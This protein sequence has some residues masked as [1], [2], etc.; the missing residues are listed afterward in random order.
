[1]SFVAI[2]GLALGLG[3]TI[4][5]AKSGSEGKKA[6]EREAELQR[7]AGEAR[8]AAAELEA[9][10]LE[11]QAGQ[12]VA[13]AQRDMFDV[14]RATRLAESRALALSAAS[15]GGASSPTVINIIANIAKEGSYNAARA[16]Y[17]GEEQARL[18]KIHAIEKR[19]LGEFDLTAGNLAGLAAEGRGKAAVT[20]SY[21]N[22]LDT[23]GSLFTKYGVGGSSAGSGSGLDFT[24]A[25]SGD[26]PNTGTYA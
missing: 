17:A 10:V 6:A 3:S 11:R 8:K 20:K 1:M 24:S 25:G 15:G 14:Q 9:D 7:R 19:R 21:A 5:S 22:I 18:M 12:T 2:A 23:T 26:I 16:L 13:A 4:L